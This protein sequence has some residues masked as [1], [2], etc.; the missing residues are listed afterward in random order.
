MIE[1]L[2]EHMSRPHG[3]HLAVD[4]GYQG[5]SCSQCL[6]TISLP[7]NPMESGN[8]RSNPFVTGLSHLYNLGLSA[9]RL[10]CG[11]VWRR[12]NTTPRTKPQHANSTAQKTDCG[13]DIARVVG[14][15]AP[16]AT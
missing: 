7:L 14:K 12:N 6:R 3:V 10:A 15:H 11:S 1:L 16:P 5:V 9:L 8:F 4:T 13:A 2:L